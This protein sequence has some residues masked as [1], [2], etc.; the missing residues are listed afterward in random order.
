MFAR[1]LVGRKLGLAVLSSHHIVLVQSA[2]K[3]GTT[4]AFK[5]AFLTSGHRKDTKER[6][7]N[8]SSA[9]LSD[10]VI[11]YATPLV[12]D[13]VRHGRDEEIR[14]EVKV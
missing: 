9:T 13:A 4:A 11:E 2:Q 10:V 12:E 14:M 6:V 3:S 8:G 5:M 7:L 1:H